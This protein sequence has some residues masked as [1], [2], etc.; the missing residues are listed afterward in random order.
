MKESY[1]VIFCFV[2]FWKDLADW[3]VERK[4]D[5]GCRK[6]AVGV[7]AVKGKHGA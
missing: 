1:F 4:V 2:S 6:S 5:F 3:S 7:A